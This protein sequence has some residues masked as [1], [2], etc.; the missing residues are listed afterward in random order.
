MSE[1][2]MLTESAKHRRLEMML[3]GETTII[4]VGDTV[5][6]NGPEG[7]RTSFIAKIERMWEAA[8]A[9]ALEGDNEF[10][11]NIRTRWYFTVRRKLWRS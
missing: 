3:N 7:S 8:T 10:G 1:S 5:S 9:A 6:L 11:M 2:L 4:E